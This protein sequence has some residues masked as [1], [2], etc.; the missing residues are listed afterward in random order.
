MN[1]LPISDDLFIFLTHK[2]EI[3][4]DRSL[5]IIRERE[6][7]YGNDRYQIALSYAPTL[8]GNKVYISSNYYLYEYDFTQSTPLKLTGEVSITEQ[9]NE[10]IIM[11]WNDDSAFKL[12]DGND[13]KIKKNG[14]V[15]GWCGLNLKFYT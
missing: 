7:T 2:R 14:F 6:I 4:T 1:C 13:S 15:E 11:D 10:L 3:L 12:R 8:T 5:G 9:N